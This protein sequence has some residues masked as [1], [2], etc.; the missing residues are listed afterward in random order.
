MSTGKQTSEQVHSQRRIRRKDNQEDNSK[1]SIN[2]DL[3]QGQRPRNALSWLRAGACESPKTLS[4]YYGHYSI[5]SAGHSSV[6]VARLDARHNDLVYNSRRDGVWNL[7]F[8]PVANFYPQPAVISHYEE[9][10]AIVNALTAHTPCFECSHGEIFDRNVTGGITDVDE[11]LMP[12]RFLVGL[13]TS[14][15]RAG[16]CWRHEAGGVCHPAR[17]RLWNCLKKE[18]GERHPFP[19]HP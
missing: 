13:K 5:H 1:N 19:Q 10:Q 18:K 7:A 3:S 11:K 15:Q 2:D 17:R 14:V 9:N 6:A 16:C 12:G 8:E 4:A